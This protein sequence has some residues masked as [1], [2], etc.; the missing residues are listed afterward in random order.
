MADN[1]SKRGRSDRSRVSASEPY[2]MKYMARKL[3][4]TSD[5]VRGLIK[6]VGDNR[7]KITEAAKNLIPGGSKPAKKSA[8]KKAAAKKALAK[9]APAK[10]PAKKSAARKAAKTSP[11]RKAPAKKSAAKKAPARKAAR[12]AARR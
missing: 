12:K 1:K 8:A 10:A 3:G 11:A 7:A 5:A 9:K 6:S 2:E 4:T